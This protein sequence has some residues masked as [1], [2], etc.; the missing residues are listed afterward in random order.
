MSMKM[1]IG[2]IALAFSAATCGVAAAAD[3]TFYIGGSMGQS[4]PNF[5]GAGNASGIGRTFNSSDGA[6]KLYG[7]YK[8]HKHFSVEGSWINLGLYDSNTSNQVEIAGWGLALV[9]HMPLAKDFTLLGRLGENRMRLKRLPSGVADTSW[10]P[11]FGVG[12]KYDFNP[13][14]SAR[15]EFERIIKMGSNSTTV[16]T[17]TNVYTIGLGYQF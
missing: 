13:N 17:D 8:F 6:Y 10:S 12:L 14:F 3:N 7:G 9:G 1:R 5:D 4:R 15:A 16:S 11:T 2:V